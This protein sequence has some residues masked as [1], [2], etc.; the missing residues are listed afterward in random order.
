MQ[1]ERLRETRLVDDNK[2]RKET[3][4]QARENEPAIQ[5]LYPQHLKKGKLER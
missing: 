5:I 3:E 1:E 4:K 2:V